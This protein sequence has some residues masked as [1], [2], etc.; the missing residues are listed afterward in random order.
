MILVLV[1][2]KYFISMQQVDYIVQI[3]IIIFL[4]YHGAQL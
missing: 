4:L 3:L 1:L 2:V